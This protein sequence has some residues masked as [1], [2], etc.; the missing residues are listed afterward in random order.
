MFRIVETVRAD[1]VA[2]RKKL[3]DNIALMKTHFGSSAHTCCGIDIRKSARFIRLDVTHST[4]VFDCLDATDKV[5]GFAMVRTNL[6][7]NCVYIALMTSFVPGVGRY[8]VQHISQLRSRV[9]RYIVL[10]STNEALGFYL[11]LGFRLFNWHGTQGYIAMNDDKLTKKLASAPNEH[12]R[13]AILEELRQRH[14]ID[15]KDTEWPLVMQR[16]AYTPTVS[17]RQSPRFR[18]EAGNRLD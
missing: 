12:A 17:V 10:R 11:K 5:V 8:L 1:D 9:Q 14:W 4:H 3:M 18:V 6:P 2:W 13:A 15:T 7:S 16:T